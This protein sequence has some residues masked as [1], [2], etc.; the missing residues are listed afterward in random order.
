[1]N[2][3]IFTIWALFNGSG[4]ALLA[5]DHELTKVMGFIAILGSLYFLPKFNST[6]QAI[7]KKR[8]AK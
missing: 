1:M 7:P 4:I 6:Y 3:R 2:N 5:M 8:L